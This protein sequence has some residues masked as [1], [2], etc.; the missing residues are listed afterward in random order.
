MHIHAL[1][2]TFPLPWQSLL[3][4]FTL[5]VTSILLLT[6]KFLV[7]LSHKHR[8]ISVGIQSYT[9]ILLSLLPCFLFMFVPR[10]DIHTGW[11]D[12]WNLISQRD[13]QG[14][15]NSI[16]SY[17]EWPSRLLP[18]VC[19]LVCACACV[20]VCVHGLR[21]AHFHKYWRVILMLSLW[22]WLTM[23]ELCPFDSLLKKAGPLSVSSA[24][25]MAW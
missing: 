17:N 3:H 1:T 8:C 13:H 22:P 7:F 4:T 10:K 14:K 15:L 9:E 19:V 16:N 23:V 18:C 12:W 24:Y 11:M 20:C 6:L 25:I 2:L 5:S 21:S